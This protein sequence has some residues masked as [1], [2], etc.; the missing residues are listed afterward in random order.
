MAV[1]HFSPAFNEILECTS[2]LNTESKH[3]AIALSERQPEAI[4]DSGKRPPFG[5]DV[6]VEFHTVIGILYQFAKHAEQDRQRREPLLTVD[7]LRSRLVRLLYEHDAPQKIRCIPLGLHRLQQIVQ[8]FPGLLSCPSVWSLVVR[9]FEDEVVTEDP[10]QRLF[11]CLDRHLYGSPQSHRQF[12]PVLSFKGTLSSRPP[13]A[14]TKRT[15][16]SVSGN[17]AL[18]TRLTSRLNRSRIRIVR[19]E[20]PP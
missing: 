8:Q 18:S 16:A 9:Y 1:R 7:H 20:N 11:F 10:P 17:R 19:S 5:P 14:S 4:L 2:L 13:T 3:L 6:A 12:R 15:W